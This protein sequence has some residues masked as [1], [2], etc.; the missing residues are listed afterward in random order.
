V[1]KRVIVH[2]ARAILVQASR[3]TRSPPPNSPVPPQIRAFFLRKL[4]DNYGHKAHNG[5]SDE[6]QC[7]PPK[8][9]RARTIPQTGSPVFMQNVS[10]FLR[11]FISAVWQ[12]SPLKQ[13]K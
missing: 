9:R 4:A 11:F 12:Y 5:N 3:P 6:N 1:K 8:P 7:N 2:S 10:Q 13:S